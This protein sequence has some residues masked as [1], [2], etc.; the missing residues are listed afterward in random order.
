MS[1]KHKNPVREVSGLLVLQKQKLKKKAGSC[2]LGPLCVHIWLSDGLHCHPSPTANIN[3]QSKLSMS[4]L[5][6][7][8]LPASCK[9]INI[10]ITT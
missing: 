2:V 1:N 8:V 9:M 5:I 4:T 3:K 6:K 7:C 10:F